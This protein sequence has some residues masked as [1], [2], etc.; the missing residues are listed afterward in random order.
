MA[1]ILTF[2][3]LMLS[4][5]TSMAQLIAPTNLRP[6]NWYWNGSLVSEWSW[7]GTSPYLWECEYS[8]NGGVTWQMESQQAAN[9]AWVH[10]VSQGASHQLRVAA[11]TQQT[12]GPYCNVVTNYGDA[13][14]D[15]IT[16]S[17]AGTSQTIISFRDNSATETGF[18]IQRAT[19]SAFT[20]NIVYYVMPGDTNIQDHLNY[21]NNDSFV[22]DTTY[23][24][25]VLMALHPYM[26]AGPTSGLE[27]LAGRILE[28]RPG[29]M[30]TF[31][32]PDGSTARWPICGFTTDH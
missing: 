18:L 21:T 13:E 10:T 12:I 19:N 27:F 5:L 1:R 26:L 3:F 16:I 20:S 25:R 22:A 24:Y 7:D 8:T 28:H 15:L 9:T 23:Y 30:M 2:A 4:A 32:M 31:Q 17:A 14:P 6:S 29:V 11:L